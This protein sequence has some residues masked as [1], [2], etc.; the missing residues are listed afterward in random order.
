[1]KGQSTNTVAKSV[2]QS[3]GEE[4]E[5]PTGSCSHV[6][7]EGEVTSNGG[8]TVEGNVTGDSLTG[9]VI[10][11]TA[12][13]VVTN[14]SPAAPWKLKVQQ[15]EENGQITAHLEPAPSSVLQFT[16]Q[17]QAFG[18]SVATCDYSSSGIQGMGREGSSEV[19]EE[20]TS[21]RKQSGGSICGEDLHFSGTGTLTSNGN[22]LTLDLT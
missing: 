9:C 19:I 7:F 15:P 3:G 6:E 22:E 1:M 2:N 11:S 4:I 21:F 10:G 12:I 13:D 5:G 8:A 14:A 17:A 20:G 16:V 18:F